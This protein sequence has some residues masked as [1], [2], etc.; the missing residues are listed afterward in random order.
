[1]GP[2]VI[3]GVLF[4]EEQQEGLRA[5]G[6]RDSKLLTPEVRAKLDPKIRDAAVKVSLVEAQPREIDE[7]V[8]HGGRLRKLN[9]LEARMMANV[10][11]DLSPE[12]AYVD[13]SDV[14]EARYA[15]SIREFLPENLHLSFVH[16]KHN[17]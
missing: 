7:F 5:I 17:S 4:P 3:A 15:A 11:T 8:L 16:P 2:L 14:N 9:F 13:A 12:E 1:M 6:V 10:L